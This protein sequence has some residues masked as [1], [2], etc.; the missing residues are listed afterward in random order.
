MTL[1]NPNFEITN[2]ILSSLAN[3]NLSCNTNAARQKT[4]T[5]T[6][7]NNSSSHLVPSARQFSDPAPLGKTPIP[8]DNV[9]TDTARVPKRTRTPA[10]PRSREKCLKMLF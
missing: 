3:F 9:A 1:G 6:I 8:L 4:A 5:K 7:Q 2:E 10:E